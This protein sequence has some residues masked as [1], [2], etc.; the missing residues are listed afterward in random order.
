[1]GWKL[2]SF[3][4]QQNN[5]I[6]S[7]FI[8]LQEGIDMTSLYRTHRENILKTEFQGQNIL[9]LSESFTR[10]EFD[11]V[12]GKTGCAGLRIYYGMDEDKK[13]HAIIVG[14]N[15]NGDDIL[16]E[17]NSLETEDDFIIERGNRCPDLCPDDSPL[18]S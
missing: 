15:E 12:L 13:I 17:E 11:T 7:H 8:S 1:M 18:N 9:P 10:S 2:S 14:T 5:I 6:M 16:P 3:A 4:I